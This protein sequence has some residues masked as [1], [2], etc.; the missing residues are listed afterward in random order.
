MRKILASLLAVALLASAVF[1]LA[2]CSVTDADTG[3]DIVLGASR[4]ASGANTP[5]ED[6]VFSFTATEV[7]EELI[8][9]ITEEDPIPPT[10]GLE[11]VLDKSEKAYSVL[12]YSNASFP[13]NPADGKRPALAAEVYVPFSYKGLPVIGICHGAFSNTPAASVTLPDTLLFIG[14]KAF[15]ASQIQSLDLPASVYSIAGDAFIDCN[16]LTAV[17]VDEGNAVYSTVD[18]YLMRGNVLMRGFTNGTIPATATE[19]ANF[20]FRGCDALTEIVVPATVTKLGDGVFANC[21]NLTTVDIQAD[22]DRLPNSALQ[23]CVALTT[24]VL[25]DSIKSIGVS[26]LSNTGLVSYDVPLGVELIDVSAFEG[27]KQLAT[28]N[29]ATVPEG[30]DAGLK[31]IGSAAFRNCD[32]LVSIAFPKGLKSI[33]ANAFKSCDSLVN[34]TISDT[35]TYIG[36][37]AFYECRNLAPITM[38]KSVNHVG[39]CAFYGVDTAFTVYLSTTYL[40]AKF[41]NDWN[42]R[43]IENALESGKIAVVKSY[44][45]YIKASE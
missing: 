39:I 41:V 11:F 1:S 2:S 29:F 21:P 38:P 16:K 9:T 45:T 26:A 42:V 27:S 18:G 31:T 15:K 20:A 36:A 13:V 3:V 35:V 5:E 10:A 30:S 23:N 6:A 22:I 24:L 34:V 43:E 8:P 7:P 33:D 4:G 32:S 44:I 28:I 25:S 40:P 37:A 12:A 14:E 19:I 17:S